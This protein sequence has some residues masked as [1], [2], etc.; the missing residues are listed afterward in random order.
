MNNNYRS[1]HGVSDDIG[2]LTRVQRPWT[3]Y[4]ESTVT[5]DV[6]KTDTPPVYT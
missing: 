3:K 1:T 6:L 5:F 2:R 4:I